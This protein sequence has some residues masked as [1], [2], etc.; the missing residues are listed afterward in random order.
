M[1]LRP[2]HAPLTA[3]AQLATALLAM[4][5]TASPL[6]ADRAVGIYSLGAAVNNPNT[7]QDDRLSNIRDYDFVSGYTLR[8]FW[9]DVETSQG[10]YD[11][12][13]I[14]AAIERLVPLNQGLSL[15]IFVGEEPQYVLDGSSA[16]Y[17]DHRGGTNPVPWDSFA[18]QRQAEL[19]AALGNHVVPSAGA[20]HLLRDDHTLLA[21][22]AAPAGLNFGVRDLNNGIR[23]H[24]DYTQ[25]RYIDAVVNGVAATAAAFPHDANFLAF[26]G[27]SDGQPGTPIDQQLIERLAPLY[28][29]PGQTE[30]AF[31]IENLSDDG[32]VPQPNGTGAGNNLLEW[33]DLGGAT[34]MQALDSWLA[35]RP[36]RDPQLDSLTPAAGIELGF[37]HYGT[38]FFELYVADLDGA[39][40]GALD[41]A[42]R[43]IIDDLRAW[44]A[45]LTAEDAPN[46][47][48]NDNGVIDANDLALW[49]SHFGAADDATPLPGDANGDQQVDGA[50]FL[51]W[52]RQ[53]ASNAAI[54]GTV[55]PEPAPSSAIVSLLFTAVAMVSRHR[56]ITPSPLINI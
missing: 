17:V 51:I 33:T 27:F 10:V 22:D 34:M 20:P 25:Q 35:H 12:S 50:D 36:D 9:K 55:V 42:G 21:I 44:Q 47:D 15:E 26:I 53:F 56:F 45:I 16:T 8:L 24:P 30:L 11:F 31:F 19:Y 54:L 49:Q 43:P 40:S 23:S 39:A 6:R 32:P 37:D 14:D 2:N 29:G 52:Q 18:Q 46:A 13:V 4:G 5:L 28:N 38:R 1:M 41:A 3:L 7:P 48:F